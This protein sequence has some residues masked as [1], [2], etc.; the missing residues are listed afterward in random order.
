MNTCTSVYSL[1]LVWFV[2]PASRSTA[3]ING[4]GLRGNPDV[5]LSKLRNN[6]C[7][8]AGVHNYCFA[9]IKENGKPINFL[10]EGPRLKS[11]KLSFFKVYKKNFLAE[12]FL[13]SV[14]SIW[15]LKSLIFWLNRYIYSWQNLFGWNVLI[16]VERFLFVLHKT[17]F[18]RI[19]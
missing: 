6:F 5:C 13:S 18:E 8:K 2:K 16:L 11:S 1:V 4:E 15:S 7:H 14:Y 17:V 10:I 12:I 19:L 9:T 3:S